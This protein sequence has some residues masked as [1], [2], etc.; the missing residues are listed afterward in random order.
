MALLTP[1][2]D[3]LGCGLTKGL[4]RAFLDCFIVQLSLSWI[5]KYAGRLPFRVCISGR[6]RL[7][8]WSSETTGKSPAYTTV[9]GVFGFGMFQYF[10]RS[11]LT[12]RCQARLS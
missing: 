5:L 9:Y 10:V 6:L 7:S 11:A 8:A 4:R 2:C 3:F 12:R 1:R